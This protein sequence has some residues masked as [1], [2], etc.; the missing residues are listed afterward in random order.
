MTTTSFSPGTTIASSWLNDVNAITYG[1]PSTASG[2][3]AAL[4]GYLPSGT[5]ASTTRTASAKLRE[6]VSVMDF[7]AVGDGVTNDTAAIN[8]AIA[9]V[10]GLTYGGAVFFP[11]GSYAVTEINATLLSSGFNKSIRLYGLGRWVS[12]IVPYAAGNVLLNMM[13]SNWMQVDG[14]HFDSTALASQCA[15][16][17]SRT[18]VSQNCNNNRFEKI[19]TSGSFSKA[20]V[21]C[22]G[23]ESSVWFNCRFDN[24]NSGSGYCL[25]W[26]GGQTGVQTAQGITTINGGTIYDSNNPNTDNRMFGCEFYAPFSNATLLKFQYGAAYWFYSCTPVAGAANNC[27]LATYIAYPGT[28]TFEGPVE[29]HGCQFEVFGTGNTLH[30]LETNGVSST[31]NGVSVYGGL[32][33]CG[34]SSP[35]AAIDFDRQTLSS[36]AILRGSTWL[37]PRSSAGCTTS[38]AYIYIL[39]GG[40]FTFKPNE[41]DGTLYMSGYAL[42]ATVDVTSFVGPATRFVGCYHTTVAA[43]LPTTGTFTVGETI[44]R[45]TPVV[46]QPTGWKCT[47][48][49]TLGTLNSGATTGTINSGSNVLTLSTATGAAEGQRITVGGNGPFYIRKLVGTTAYVDA[50]AGALY[51]GT[52]AF[53]PATL[54]AMANL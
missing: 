34:T 45:E 49:G 35:T 30:W 54:V 32:M 31:F 22:N 29:W 28:A 18:T 21:V 47:V 14:L 5:G 36:Q 16:F 48:S 13:G 41:G 51:S 9:Y 44:Q 19:Y 2:Q 7:G 33:Q 15:I 38:V 25:L 26:T 8:A 46:G 4:V 11:A 50:N 23:S 52:I 17:M 10:N 1:V 27:K 42:N 37:N 40:T 12:R 6:T 24:T 53:S 43:A 39:M 20:S 3:G